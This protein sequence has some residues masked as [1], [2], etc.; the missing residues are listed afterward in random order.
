[1]TA[2]D[3]GT[4]VAWTRPSPTVTPLTSPFWLAAANGRLTAQECLSCGHLRYPIAH[5]CPNCLND[6]CSWRELSGS[7]TVF[8]RVVYHRAFNESFRDQVPYIVAIVQLDEGPRMLSNI[9]GPDRALVRIGSRVRVTFDRVGDDVAVPLFEL[10]PDADSP[11]PISER[12]GT[13]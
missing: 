3:G 12:E 9:V 7:G 6:A 11:S 13:V 8:S 10:A 2:L 1:M 4:G 5:V